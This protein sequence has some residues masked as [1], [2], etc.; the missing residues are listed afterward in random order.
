MTKPKINQDY[1]KSEKYD[2]EIR[3]IFRKY[4][5][6]EVTF[7]IVLNRLLLRKIIYIKEDKTQ[8]K[9]ESKR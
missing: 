8:P 4:L 9:K 6:R 1:K 2:F 3:D 5:N 7:G